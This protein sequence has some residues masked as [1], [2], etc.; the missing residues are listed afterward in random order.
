M[1]AILS[2][3]I[4]MKWHQCQKVK[5]EKISSDHFVA[6]LAKGNVSFCHYLSCIVLRL[7]SVNFSI[8]I[9]SSEIAQPI[10][11]KLGRKY[12]W[13]VLYKYCSICHNPFTNMATVKH[14]RQAILVSGWS[15]SKK[16][17]SLKPLVQMNRNLWKVLYELC[18]FCRNPFTNMATKG[19]SCFWLVNF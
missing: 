12:L 18:S 14:D 4:Q 10:E 6:H 7:S 2:S 19:N 16:S 13:K 17:S 15:F 9:F 5:I 3:M 11:P 8:L 1:L